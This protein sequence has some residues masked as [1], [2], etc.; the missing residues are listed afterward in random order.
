MKRRLDAAAQDELRDEGGE[1][2]LILRAHGGES[3]AE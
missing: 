2:L 1:P 3:V